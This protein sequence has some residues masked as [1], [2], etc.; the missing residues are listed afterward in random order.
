MVSITPSA[1]SGMWNAARDGTM[2]DY[3]LSKFEN[4]EGV[5]DSS[6]PQ[7]RLFLSK[8]P[9]SIYYFAMKDSSS[10]HLTLERKLLYS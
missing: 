6:S 5:L 8:H 1:G 9:A 7:G 10:L 2:V 3:I 4:L